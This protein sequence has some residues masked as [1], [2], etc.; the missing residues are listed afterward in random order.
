MF[1]ISCI[2]SH[3]YLSLRVCLLTS[4]NGCIL[5]KLDVL[6]DIDVVR[7]ARSLH[8]IW[9]QRVTRGIVSLHADEGFFL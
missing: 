5:V 9:S 2:I 4:V 1:S 3:T 6:G 8:D 7:E